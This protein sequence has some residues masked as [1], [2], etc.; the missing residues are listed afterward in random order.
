MG[1]ERFGNIDAIGS[2]VGDENARSGTVVEGANGVV[3]V[4][5]GQRDF[6]GELGGVRELRKAEVL[7]RD[8]DVGL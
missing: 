7:R 8:S 5:E 6:G 4:R 2:I 3:A 1:L